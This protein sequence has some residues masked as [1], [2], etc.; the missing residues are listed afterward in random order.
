MKYAWL[1]RHPKI[2]HDPTTKYYG[3]LVLSLIIS[4]FP[5]LQKIVIQVLDW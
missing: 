1:R 4:K 5:I 2:S 3:Q